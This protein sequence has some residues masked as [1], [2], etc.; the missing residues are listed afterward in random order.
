[1]EIA[2]PQA[3]G[4]RAGGILPRL[5]SN[6]TARLARPCSSQYS[7]DRL[8]HTARAGA[9]KDRPA[10]RNNGMPLREPQGSSMGDELPEEPILTGRAAS[11]QDAFWARKAWELEA[12][13]PAL[14]TQASQQMMS[15]TALLSGIY[16]A[17]LG[18]FGIKDA[19]SLSFRTLSLAP[20]L[21]WLPAFVC[22]YLAYRPRRA[23]VVAG[24]A[25]ECRAMVL[26]LSARKR[27]WSRAAE[28]LLLGGL[29]MAVVWVAFFLIQGSAPQ[30]V[31]PAG[32]G[33]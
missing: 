24:C 32:T 28:L 8:G 2:A 26:E 31:T 17:T 4:G 9:T 13:G 1:M 20:Y 25:S 6:Q 10:H 14:L 18:V 7:V 15:L 29:V 22:A 19:D 27:R 5:N 12:D 23:A 11:V 16:L 21:A 3:W 30:A 33:D